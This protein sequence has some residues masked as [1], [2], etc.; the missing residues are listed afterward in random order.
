MISGYLKLRAAG[1]RLGDWKGDRDALVDAAE[2]LWTAGYHADSWPK[3][4]KMRYDRIR[5]RLF[6][7]GTVRRTLACLPDAEAADL[8]DEMQRFI[9]AALSGR[10]SWL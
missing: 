6:T 3:Y 7:G 1:V 5:Y 4:V 2:D 10:S 8:A 9:E